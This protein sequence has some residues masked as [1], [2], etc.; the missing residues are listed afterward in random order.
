M[1]KYNV[2]EVVA[3]MTDVMIFFTIFL[4]LIF[5]SSDLS[6]SGAKENDCRLF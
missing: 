1:Q 5:V 4:L 3:H 6:V 2:R